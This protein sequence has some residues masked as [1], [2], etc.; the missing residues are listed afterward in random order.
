MSRFTDFIVSILPK[1]I[2]ER[3]ED[4]KIKKLEAGAQEALRL[5]CKADG[6]E[7]E[8]QDYIDS[9]ES[10]KRDIEMYEG[11]LRDGI[12]DAPRWKYALKQR[13][14]EMEFLRPNNPKD[15][16]ERNYWADNFY[17]EFLKVY[18]ESEDLRFHGTSIYNTKAILESG[19]IF[20]S[21]DINDAI[22]RIY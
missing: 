22:V 4:S 1:G 10:H 18:P 21:V 8:Y 3:I 20:S 14:M 13:Q 5:Q 16:E 9:I 11:Y 15:I 19:G 6:R 2:R 17:K 12:A 7:T